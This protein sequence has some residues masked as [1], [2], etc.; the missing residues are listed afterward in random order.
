MASKK[1]KHKIRTQFRKKHQ[2]RSKTGDLTREF[3]DQADRLDKL[4]PTERISG[5]GELTR[6]RTVIGAELTEDQSGGFTV[7]L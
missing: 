2:G 7:L 5:K 4:A 3:Q 1:Q 6:K